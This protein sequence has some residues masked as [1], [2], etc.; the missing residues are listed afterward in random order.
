MKTYSFHHKDTGLLHGKRVVTDFVAVAEINTPADHVVI[1]GEY[2]H[3]SQKVDTATG[4]VVDYQPPQPTADHEWNADEKRWNLTQDALTRRHLHAM[5]VDGILTL[6]NKQLRAMREYML[7][8]TTA[9]RRLKDIDDQIAA[10]RK[11][12]K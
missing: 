2:D 12:L 5:A 1:E 7:G 3:L 11:D 9:V 8:D 10:L 4:A 6:E